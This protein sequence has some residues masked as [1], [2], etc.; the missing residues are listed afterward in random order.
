MP[1]P[2]FGPG[3]GQTKNALNYS[4]P[5]LPSRA[6]RATHPAIPAPE[7]ALRALRTTKD[8]EISHQARVLSK[9]PAGLLLPGSKLDELSISAAQVLEFTSNGRRKV[10]QAKSGPITKN[11]SN[12]QHISRNEAA[13]AAIGGVNI[14]ISPAKVFEPCKSERLGD[15]I[16]GAGCTLKFEEIACWCL[17]EGQVQTRKTKFGAIFL[18]AECWSKAEGTKNRGPAVRILDDEFPFEPL[19]EA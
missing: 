12:E 3:H 13:T 8:G 5:V 4:R 1:A 15:A 17:V 18:V 2:E 7:H 10:C 11:L 6:S 16:D 14:P 19:F 9:L